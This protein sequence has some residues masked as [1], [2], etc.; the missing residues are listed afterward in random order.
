MT[1]G[2][3][4]GAAG[5]EHEERA[6]FGVIEGVGAESEA[7]AG[8]VGASQLRA[9]FVTS[10][11]WTAA[12][13]IDQLRRGNIDLNPRFQRRE[14]W[15]SNRKS[16]FIESL[17][18]NLPVP[19]I[20]LAEKEA[21]R[22]RYIV[23]DGKQRLLTLRQF[24][25][26]PG[27]DQD[28]EFQEL[29]LSGL[30]L[31][32]SL[33]GLSY[34]DLRN[35]PGF[36]DDLDAFDNSTIRTVVVRNW[37]NSD[38]LFLVFLRLNS[39]SVPLSPQELRQ[40]LMPGPFTDYV[41]ERALDSKALREAL[42]QSG[43][44]FRM[45]DNEIL[46]RAIAFRLRP[47]KYRGNLKLFLDETCKEYNASWADQESEVISAVDQIESAIEAASE[48][49]GSR[50]AFSRFT[51]GVPERRFNRA[52]YDV[53]VHS[54]AQPLVRTEALGNREVVVEALRSLCTD[55]EEFVTA[56]TTTTKSTKATARRFTYWADA[57]ADAL[58][59]AVEVPGDYRASI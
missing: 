16:R 59:V 5:G 6:H 47:E 15:Q 1:I 41:D 22:G 25:A 37:P 18:L 8:P 49:F 21:Q 44:D 27:S 14:V 11:D 40:A 36:L 9:A 42:N 53:L 29:H 51:D 38:Y 17:I 3:D 46:L 4:Q 31:L 28:A 35:E 50:S 52:V 30:K 13:L 10:S 57:L 48:I 56:I 43:A 45:R 24:C 32:P 55:N 2:G 7:D 39:E 34:G 20:V 54:L 26:E 19:Q 12:T 23:L 58:G 33:N